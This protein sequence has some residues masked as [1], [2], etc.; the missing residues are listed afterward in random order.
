MKVKSDDVVGNIT[1]ELN[2]DKKSVAQSF[3]GI[4]AMAAIRG[5]AS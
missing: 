4:A 2:A 5:S 3:D 1:E